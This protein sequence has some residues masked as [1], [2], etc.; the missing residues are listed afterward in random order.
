MRKFN[1][2]VDGIDPKTFDYL[3][4]IMIILIVV[5]HVSSQ[6]FSVTPSHEMRETA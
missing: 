1:Y 6:N 3:F 2:K 4:F 5:F